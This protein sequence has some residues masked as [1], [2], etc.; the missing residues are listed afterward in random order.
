MA[1]YDSNKQYEW[2][3]DDMFEISGN[4]LGLIL[5]TLRAILDTKE[6][7]QILLA[8]RANMAIEAIM[9]K[10]VESDVI[11]ETIPK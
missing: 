9:A 3:P 5:N 7:Y 8:D 11:K 10:Y 4:D 1:I 6:A 2:K